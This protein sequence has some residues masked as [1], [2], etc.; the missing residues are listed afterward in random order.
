MFLCIGLFVCLFSWYFSPLTR[1][2]DSQGPSGRQGDAGEQMAFFS[3]S[4][5]RLTATAETLELRLL[6]FSFHLPGPDM[7]WQPS[8]ITFHTS[9]KEQSCSSATTGCTLLLS[10]VLTQAHTGTGTTR[11]YLSDHPAIICQLSCGFGQKI[12]RRCVTWL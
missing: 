12:M 5:C 4:A 11:R 7:G 3:S 2:Q 1:S 9:V 10:S 8:V 6:G